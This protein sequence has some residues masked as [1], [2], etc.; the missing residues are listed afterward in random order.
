MIIHLL[1]FLFKPV[2]ARRDLSLIVRPV[3]TASGASCRSSLFAGNSIDKCFPG[4]FLFLAALSQIV[5][6]GNRTL[7]FASG[8]RN[9]EPNYTPDTARGRKEENDNGDL[10][11]RQPRY[12]P[13]SG[14]HLMVDRWSGLIQQTQPCGTNGQMGGRHIAVLLWRR[15]GSCTS[16]VC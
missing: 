1:V 4:N 7:P 3:L 6:S 12:T 8:T 16:L 13:K 5:P 9:H 11:P 2:P 14:E 15:K 10:W